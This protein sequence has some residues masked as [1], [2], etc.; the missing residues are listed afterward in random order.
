VEIRL[1]RS[2]HRDWHR[3]DEPSL[4]R[5][6]NNRNVWPNLRDRFHR[7]STAAD[8]E[9][10]ISIESMESPVPDFAIVVDA[11]TVAPALPGTAGGLPSAKA[12]SMRA[13]SP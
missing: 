4:L 13:N 11:E 6:A 5:H 9:A 10:L 8:A 12:Y 3:S 7:P 1:S 2:T